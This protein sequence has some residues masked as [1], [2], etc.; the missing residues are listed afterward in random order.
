MTEKPIIN[1][2]LYKDHENR[3][4]LAGEHPFGDTLQLI[5]L[6]IFTAAIAVDYFFFQTYQILEGKISFMVRLPIGLVLIAF[7]GWLA[8]Y[9]IQIVF[10]DLRPEPI[11]ITKGM[12]SKVRHPIYLGAMLVYLGVLCLTLSFLGAVVFLFVLLVYQWL[13]KHEEKLM[14]DIFGDTYRDYIQRVPMWVPRLF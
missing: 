5:M 13:A 8:L 10:R 11:M 6:I 12:F 9:G 3:P 7:G 4:D 14:L 2:E 1:E